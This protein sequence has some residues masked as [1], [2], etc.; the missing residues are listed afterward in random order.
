M[1]LLFIV[2]PVSLLTLPIL[3]WIS[4]AWISNYHFLSFWLLPVL[5]LVIT[6]I[7]T[8]VNR[9]LFELRPCAKNGI[10]TITFGN[11]YEARQHL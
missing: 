3:A 7:P 8:R 4:L 6:A 10:M 2:Y 9:V 5:R 11:Y 1:R